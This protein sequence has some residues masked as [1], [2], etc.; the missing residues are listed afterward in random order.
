MIANLK[1][2]LN[3]G[4]SVAQSRAVVLCQH[5]RHSALGSFQGELNVPRDSC[6]SVNNV[7]VT[8]AKTRLT[9]MDNQPH[10]LCWLTGIDPMW[11]LWLLLFQRNVRLTQLHRSWLRYYE[12]K[13]MSYQIYTTLTRLIHLTAKT[14]IYQLNT[15]TIPAEH[16]STAWALFIFQRFCSC[17]KDFLIYIAG[18]VNSTGLI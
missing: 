14:I 3:V 13:L 5:A 1:I 18:S 11:T 8:S 2:I 12:T 6:R 7:V 4:T 9:T 10:V 16:Q 15:A 17:S